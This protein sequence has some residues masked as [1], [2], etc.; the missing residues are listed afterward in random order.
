MGRHFSKVGGT[1]I[2]GPLK[3]KS[4]GAPV[5][6]PMYYYYYYQ[7]GCLASF[8]HCGGAF[9]FNSCSVLVCFSVFVCDLLPETILTDFLCSYSVFQQTGSAQAKNWRV[10]A[11][12]D[13]N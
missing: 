9:S 11:Q 3:Q 1:I 4:Q 6:T 12:L 2:L 10:N 5:P 8:R 7:C 13:I